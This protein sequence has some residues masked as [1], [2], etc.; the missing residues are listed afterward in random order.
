MR[1]VVVIGGGLS[2]CWAAATAAQAGAT[3][4]LVRS[5]MGATAVSSGALDFVPVADASAA[6]RWLAGLP[7]SDPRHPYVAGD[8]AP[9]LED[10]SAEASRLAGALAAA[11]LPH[12]V[13]LRDPVL[14]AAI[15]GQLRHAG[16][17][18]STIAGGDLRGVGSIVVAGI[19]GLARVRPGL[20]AAAI[21]ERVPPALAVDSCSVSLPV[22]GLDDAVRADLDDA[23]VARALEAPGGAEAFGAAIRASLG[24]AQ[25]DRVLLPAVLGVADA[26][27]T[28]A[29]LEAAAGVAVA[30]LLTP[31]PSAPGWRLQAA[32]DRVARLAGVRVINGTATRVVRERTRMAAVETGDGVVYPC[33]VLILATGKYIGG[34]LR[35]EPRLHEAL[36]DLPV[37]VDGQDAGSIGSRDLTERTRF[38]DQ[39]FAGAGLRCDEQGRPVDAFGRVVCGNLLAC[40]ALL[41][42][43][44]TTLR[45]GGLGVAA[46]SAGRAGR[47]A[48]SL[49]GAAAA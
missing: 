42:G 38:R 48:A 46:W 3:V 14:V 7:R 10:L 39:P 28:S 8:A 26:P 22:D 35:A 24:K 49:V 1:E 13:N 30:E 19:P 34:G 15:T 17:V 27:A 25:P 11:R 45:G 37:F 18:Q 21:R 6:E 12:R 29:R 23:T 5:A 31:P 44:E 47:V 9:S 4:T 16:M 20:V 2:G 40:G 43:V 32:C 41:A 33:D 36:L